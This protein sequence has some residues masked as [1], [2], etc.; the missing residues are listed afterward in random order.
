MGERSEKNVVVYGLGSERDVGGVIRGTLR[1]DA[2]EA[3]AAFEQLGWFLSP[4]FEFVVTADGS[5]E[6]AYGG[7]HPLDLC[8]VLSSENLLRKGS[9]KTYIQDLGVMSTPKISKG[10][11]IIAIYV[12][13]SDLMICGA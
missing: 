12:V 2:S 9:E 5:E 6:L 4:Q 1:E 13:D 3:S 10:P 11:C 8:I 7:G